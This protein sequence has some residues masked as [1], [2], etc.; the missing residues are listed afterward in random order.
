MTTITFRHTKASSSEAH[1]HIVDYARKLFML[2]TSGRP[3]AKSNPCP[4]T[5]VRTLAGRRRMARMN[6][7]LCNESD[8]P[9]RV[10]AA[11]AFVQRRFL[12]L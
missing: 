2:G 4:S 12:R 10:R 7:R 6:A 8:I 3:P 5:C 11:P 9:P 1:A